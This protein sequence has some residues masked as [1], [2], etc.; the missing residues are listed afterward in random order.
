MPLSG[1]SVASPLLLDAGLSS[2]AGAASRRVIFRRVEAEARLLWRRRRDGHMVPQT[3]KAAPGRL[4]HALTP[5]EFPKPHHYTYILCAS[6]ATLMSA[7][8]TRRHGNSF[9]DCR[10]V[11]SLLYRL[12]V[13]IKFLYCVISFASKALLQ[14]T[15]PAYI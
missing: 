12:T 3:A 7:D 1:G 8:F 6:A 11:R 13:T 2:L 15:R 9:K 10:S 4:L 5:Y 14:T